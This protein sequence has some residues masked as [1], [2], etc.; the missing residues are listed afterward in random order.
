MG[1]PTRA[2][3]VLGAVAIL[4]LVLVAF[5]AGVATERMRFDAQRGDMLKRWD[6]ALKAHQQRIMQSEKESR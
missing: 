2:R 1:E 5:A 6:A 4:L 3:R